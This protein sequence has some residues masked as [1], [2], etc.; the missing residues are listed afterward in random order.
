MYRIKMSSFLERASQ[1]AEESNNSSTSDIPIVEKKITPVELQRSDP[2]VEEQTLIYVPLIDINVENQVRKQFDEEYISDLACDFL[3]AKD[4]QP[5]SPI[6]LWL[7]GEQ[8]V[9][10]TG[11]NRLRA[12]TVN[13]E[14]D[15]S[16]PAVIK[17]IVVGKYPR[18]KASR[19]Q[20]QIK[21]N[22]LRKNLNLGELALA[23]Q[24]YFN[25][26]P[27]ANNVDA[28]KWCGYVNSDSGRKKIAKAKLLMEGDPEILQKVV[29][30]EMSEA[31][32]I[33]EIKPKNTPA[34]E[35]VSIYRKCDVDK[36]LTNIAN[37]VQ[38]KEDWTL[39]D[40]LLLVKT[41]FSQF[42]GGSE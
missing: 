8:Y 18:S 4:K 22:L 28:A 9:L 15:N 38:S 3:Q 14:A 19:L 37:A 36:G 26:N 17:S 30:G 2:L 34:P 16:N 5:T 23:L 31:K 25:E 40:I 12:L 32:A 7:K 33:N 35:I 6:S 10:A 13:Y 21:E 1:L 41:E 39:E 27:K 24:S 11:E 20:G 29:A 42:V